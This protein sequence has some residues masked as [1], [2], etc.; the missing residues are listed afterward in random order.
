MPPKPIV[1]PERTGWRDTSL[2]LRHRLWGKNC[3][4]TDIDFLEYDSGRGVALCEW[5]HERA[6]PYESLDANMRARRHLADAA[7]LP[8]FVIIRAD[9]CSWFEVIP[10]NNKAEEIMARADITDKSYR[11]ESE[12]E[13]VGFL[14]WLRG[15]RIPQEVVNAITNNKF[16]GRC[17]L[18]DL[19]AAWARA[20]HE[21]RMEFTDE[22]L[23]GTL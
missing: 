18:D 1:Q 23:G 6:A 20:G 4:A 19:R 8:F 22:I 5:K 10:E 11:A 15:R 14:Y 16:V 13:F 3:P 9:D 17:P 7:K 21:A 12:V 2:S